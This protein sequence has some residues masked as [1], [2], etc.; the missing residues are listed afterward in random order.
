[1][2]NGGSRDQTRATQAVE[3]RPDRGDA[4][5][6]ILRVVA[7]PVVAETIV[8]QRGQRAARAPP[9]PPRRGLGI[10]HERP[11]P[12]RPRPRVDAQRRAARLGPLD[13]AERAVATVMERPPQATGRRVVEVWIE[14]V[15]PIA[16]GVQ[17]LRSPRGE[18]ER[19]ANGSPRP[20]PWRAPP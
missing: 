5:R 18:R 1:M 6:G 3:V 17:R 2:L 16:L 9:L 11:A 19:C 10:H 7:E 20:A 12:L 13:E 8:A 4:V 14:I 15:A